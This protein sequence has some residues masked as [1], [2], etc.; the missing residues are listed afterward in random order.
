MVLFS[1]KGIIPRMM[2]FLTKILLGVCGCRKHQ[3]RGGGYMS[4]VRWTEVTN[5]SK[6]ERFDPIKFQWDNNG[7]VEFIVPFGE[8]NLRIASEGVEFN[9]YSGFVC[10]K[11]LEQ[12]AQEKEL[13]HSGL[14]LFKGG[15][16]DSIVR[17]FGDNSTVFSK[18]FAS[19][20]IK[21]GNISPLT[22]EKG[23]IRRKK[24]QFGN[25]ELIS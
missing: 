10:P 19:I 1:L 22:G 7:L 4:K 16:G 8:T 15:S 25:G 17:R 20:M 11:Y 12:Y 21:I 3:R 14:E 24:M 18:S 9:R 2:H 5:T 13:L 6:K 23:I